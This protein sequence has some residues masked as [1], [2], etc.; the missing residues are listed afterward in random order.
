L[1][2]PYGVGTSGFLFNGFDYFTQQN[3]MAR[4]D[5][6]WTI[7]EPEHIA[8]WRF[9]DSISSG[10]SWNGAVRF[11]GIQYATNFNTQPSLITFPQPAITG[12]A[13][14]PSSINILV[15]GT[16][17]YQQ[18]VGRGPFYV[19][20]VPVVTGAGNIQVTTTDMLGRQQISTFSYYASP[21]LLKPGLADYS[22]EIGSIRSWYGIEDNHY[23]R[24]IGVGTYSLGLT[25]RDTAGLH[26]ELLQDE[27]TMSVSNNYLLGSFGILSLGVSGSRVSGQNSFMNG[28]IKRGVGGLVNL[29]FRRQTNF[30][31]YGVQTTLANHDYMQIGTFRDMGYPNV[32]LQSFV[33][34]STENL[35]S[36]SATFTE[37]NNAFNLTKPAPYEYLFPN[38]EVLMLSYSRNVYKQLFLTL[39][40]IGDLKSSGNKQFSASLILPLDGGD[41]SVSFNEYTNNNQHQ[42]NIQFVKNI[43]FGNGYGYRLSA[44]NNNSTP[45]IG[46]INVQT[47]QG[48]LGARYLNIGNTHNTELNARGSLIH[49]AHRTFLARYVDQSFA[50]VKIPG[51]KNVGVYSRN[52][53][54]GKTNR[55]G[56]LYIPQLLAYQRNQINIAT[57]DFPLNTKLSEVS[58]TVVPYKRS[59]VLVVFNVQLVQNILLTLYESKGLPIP[60]GAEVFLD[61]GSA[62]LPVGYYGQV[63]ISR[64]AASVVSGQATWGTHRC[65]FKVNLAKNALTIRKESALCY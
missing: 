20:Q 57:S 6:T 31:S 64:P 56:Y 15:N 44:A 65:Q 39:S 3:N 23:G 42:E 8:S 12:E 24:A 16:Q 25:E 51:F 32:T 54:I 62:P 52:Q 19:T 26:V 49:F 29:G 13:V 5:S 1:F 48:L 43:P 50:L 46:D 11:G 63:F 55:S 58:Q 2:T 30:L 38:S 22:F 28:A 9:G 35:G 21:A 18:T 45:V 7:D 27:Q 47:N 37:L 41:K 40:C 17:S 10:L 34:I 59:G 36:F 60:A 14:L 4:L 61:G 33:G 53:L